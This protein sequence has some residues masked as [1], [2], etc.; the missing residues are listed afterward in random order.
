[1]KVHLVSYVDE[2]GDDLCLFVN[3]DSYEQAVALWQDYFQLEDDIAPTA[4]YIVPAAGR[5]AGAYE[6]LYIGTAEPSDG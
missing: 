3:V 6:W 2:N 4:V 5:V 1:M